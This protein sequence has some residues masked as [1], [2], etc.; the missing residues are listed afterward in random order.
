M[1]KTKEAKPQEDDLLVSIAKQELWF[2]KGRIPKKIAKKVWY[3]MTCDI[4][5]G[6]FLCV[7]TVEMIETQGK[8]TKS[9][10]WLS[11]KTHR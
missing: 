10:S 6:L 8:R 9:W 4:S 11:L 7:K 5:F 2:Y 1:K 3:G